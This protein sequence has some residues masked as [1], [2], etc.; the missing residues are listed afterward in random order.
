[1]LMQESIN[2]TPARNGFSLR[3]REKRDARAM[4]QLF[5]QPRCQRA[6]VLEPFGSA[7]HVQAWFDSQGPNA[8]DMVATLNDRAIGFAGLYPFP[9]AQN[10]SGWMCRFIHDEFHRRGVGTMMMR[11]LLATSDLLAG[12]RR[13]QLVVFCDNEPAI[14]LY[15]KF[16]FAIEGRHDCFAR[17][18]EMFLAAFTMARI[19]APAKPADTDRMHETIHDLLSRGA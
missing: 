1:M 5:S 14:A 9:G 18:G 6:M 19:V 4:F 15:R 7:D 12:L 2:A 11:A 17:Q 8:F 3:R 10:H 13:I 16:G